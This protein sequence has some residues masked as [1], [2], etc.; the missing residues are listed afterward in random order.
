[1]GLKSGYLCMAG[2]SAL[3][4]ALLGELVGHGGSVVCQGLSAYVPQDPWIMSGTVR[5]ALPRSALARRPVS[6]QCTAVAGHRL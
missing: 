6:M 2:K 4:Q 3:L 1:M 5:S